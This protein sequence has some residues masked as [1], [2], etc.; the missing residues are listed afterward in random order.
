[1]VAFCE[2]FK[3]RRFNGHPC[4]MQ[5]RDNKQPEQ[6][7]RRFCKTLERKFCGI[8]S[9]MFAFCEK[10]RRPCP[11][12]YGT[13]SSLNKLFHEILQNSRKN[14]FAD[15]FRGF[16][17][18]EFFKIKQFDDRPCPM[19]CGTASSVNKIFTKCCKNPK[20]LI[21]RNYFANVRILQIF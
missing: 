19:Q 10:I 12:R 8:I 21:S 14:N 3:I 9:R 20:R 15:L 2:F 7:F 17:F 6:T 11:C 4:P 16:P 5:V 1:M 18:C 13:T